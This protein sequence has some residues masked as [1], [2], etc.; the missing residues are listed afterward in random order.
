MR[1]PREER[2]AALLTVLLLVAVMAT[3]AA[4]ALDRIGVGTR[5]LAN[6]ASI[7]QA[8]SWLDMAEQLAGTRIE[9]LLAADASQTTLA[10]GLLGAERSIDLPDGSVAKVRIDDGGNCFNLNSL[11]QR[12]QDGRMIARPFAARQFTALMESLGIAPGDAATIAASATDYV[13]P[14]SVPLPGGSEDGEAGPSAN[15]LIAHASELRL[16]PNVTDRHYQLLERWI[17]ALPVAELSPI[18]VNTLLAEQAP[19]VAMLVPGQIDVTR[20]RSQIAARP[21]DGYGSVLN[22]WQTPVMAGLEV[23]PEA[24]EQIKVRTGFFILRARVSAGDLEVAE[25]AL[26]DAR[27][28]PVRLLHRQWGQSS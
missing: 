1:V 14:D 22:F 24:A 13:D 28:A 15:H 26:F 11:V 21:A 9:D 19:L 10:A 17:C 3:V 2:G 8:R 16:V 23:P 7:A 6:A 25:T 20:A 27:L 4:T 5:F 18:N 12:L